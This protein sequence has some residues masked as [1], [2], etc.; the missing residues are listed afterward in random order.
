M[1]AKIRNGDKVIVTTGVG[2]GANLASIM[3]MVAKNGRCAYT[4]VAKMDDNDV[5]LNLFDLAMQQKSI[6][7]SIF[8]T[9]MSEYTTGP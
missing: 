3:G 5:Q 2:E 1:A 7:G 9:A 4:S 6:V 8:G